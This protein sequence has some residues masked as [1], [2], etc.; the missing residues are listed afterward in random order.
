MLRIERRE[1]AGT[2]RSHTMSL[3]SIHIQPR[4]STVVACVLSS[5]AWVASAAAPA[6]DASSAPYRVYVT[7]EVSGDLTIIDG[8]TRRAEAN[9][10]LGKRPRGIRA[11]HDGKLLYIAMSGSPLAPPGVD[12]SKL[13]PPDKAADGIGVFDIGTQKIVRTIKGVSDPE[14]LVLS[15]DESRLYVAS[16][17]ASV[18]VVIDVASGKTLATL[19][20]GGEPEGIALEPH[21]KY[22][23]MSSE[24]DS[25]VSVI[26]V[27]TN[28]IIKQFRVGQRP[29]GIAFAPDGKRAYITGEN[30]GSVTVVDT[31][32]HEPIHTIKLS[33][34]KARPMGIVVSGG[35]RTLYVATGRGRSV[36]SIDAN[37]YQ[38]TGAVEVGT[39]PWGIAA[40]PDGRYLYTANGP[41]ND[42][43]IVE[44]GTLKIVDRVPAGKSP[45]GMCIVPQAK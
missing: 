38:E 42:V 14:Q 16:E 19:P 1:G 43:T 9:V 25:Q 7:N 26:D 11:S 4:L 15:G 2:H 45:W 6:P 21:G 18:A 23:Y 36:V 32:R 12:E 22:V 41:S 3:A 28:R 24:A 27:G 33:D 31:S 37:T 17:D 44:A 20:V 40:S 34:S 5:I 8:A 13:P 35:A 10:P 29:R 39:R 30:D